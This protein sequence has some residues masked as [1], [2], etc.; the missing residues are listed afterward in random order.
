MSSSRVDSLVGAA[1]LLVHTGISPVR[2]DHRYTRA[3]PVPV[4]VMSSSAESP[5]SLTA[6]TSS[7][8]L[9]GAGVRPAI[10]T[11]LR[12]DWAIVCGDSVPSRFPLVSVG[13]GAVVG[14]S[15]GGV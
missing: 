15:A 10:G 3:V 13:F 9:A 4:D 2:P 1:Q 5:L 14:R 8:L 7:R 11:P 12:A 6:P